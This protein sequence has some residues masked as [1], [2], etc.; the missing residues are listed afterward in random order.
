M[1]RLYRLAGC[2]SCLAGVLA[3]LGGHWATVQSYA[4]AR[5]FA[6]FSQTESIGNALRMTFDGKHPCPLCRKVLQ[7]A[8]HERQDQEKHPWVKVDKKPEL[9]F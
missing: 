3:T 7:G 9:F 4:W 5:M 6:G 1:K 8:Q 2:L